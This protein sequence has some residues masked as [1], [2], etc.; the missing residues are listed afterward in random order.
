MLKKERSLV[1]TILFI[2]VLLLAVVAGFKNT[3]PL[4][5]QGN[6]QEILSTKEW[7]ADR[8]NSGN[9]DLVEMPDGHD[10]LII[11]MRSQGRAVAMDHSTGCRKCRQQSTASA[12]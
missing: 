5:A 11:S 4:N 1:G 9:I 10:Y 8:W 2:L 7:L 12:K 3:P 6:A